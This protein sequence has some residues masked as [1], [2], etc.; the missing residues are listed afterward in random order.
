MERIS[1]F[2]AVVDKITTDR[3]GQTKVIL[4]VPL[5][6]MPSVTRLLLVLEQS[7]IITVDKSP[8]D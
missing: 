6:D 1:Q 3:H 2:S 8:H 7:V 4:E 5:S